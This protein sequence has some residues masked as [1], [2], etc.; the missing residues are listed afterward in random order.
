MKEGMI[1]K[2]SQVCRKTLGGQH[3]GTL[4]RK[5]ASLGAQLKCLNANAHSMGNKQEDLETCARLQGY[6]FTGT[7]ETWWDGS[8][9]WSD[10]LCSL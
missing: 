7:A 9:D 4:A 2:G 10:W 6:D 5:S 1:N 8:Y 3:K